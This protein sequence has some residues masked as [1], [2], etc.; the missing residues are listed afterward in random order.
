MKILWSGLLTALF[1][2]GLQAAI[3]E[4]YLVAGNPLDD[5]I[6]KNLEDLKARPDS[7][8]LHNNLGVLLNQKQFPKDA[9]REFKK[10]VKLDKKDYQAW[11][12]V[13]LMQESMGR[14]YRALRAFKKTVKY[15]SGHDL[16]HYHIGMIYERW[17]FRRAAIR[18]YAAAIRFNSKILDHAYNPA[19]IYNEIL[20][21]VLSYI[22]ERFRTSALQPYQIAKVPPPPAPAPAPSAEPAKP[23]E[24]KQ[25]EPAP[26]AP[27]PP[28]LKRRA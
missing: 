3:Y 11:F 12:N 21:E 27:K 17:G 13:G 1:A 10:A 2:L 23:R 7:S 26:T 5:K 16:A 18:R 4:K 25:A 15:K 28:D 22:Y 9:L 14:S 20:P 6:L 19:I 8:E 24:P